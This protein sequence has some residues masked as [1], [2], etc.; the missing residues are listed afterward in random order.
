ML[1]VNTLAPYLLTGLMQRPDRLIYMTSDMHVSGDDS[2]HD[3]DRDAPRRRR[4]YG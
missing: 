2:L 4:R 1:A 3:L